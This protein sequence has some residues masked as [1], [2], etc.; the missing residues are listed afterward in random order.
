M[1]LHNTVYSGNQVDF[2]SMQGDLFIVIENDGIWRLMR[3]QERSNRKG[4]GVE[5]YPFKG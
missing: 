2:A 3:N 5:L 1:D 4:K